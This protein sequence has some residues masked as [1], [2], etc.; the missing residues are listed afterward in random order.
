MEQF[1][2][3]LLFFCL[4]SQAPA[5]LTSQHSGFCYPLSNVVGTLCWLL[6]RQQY[7][8]AAAVADDELARGVA[9]VQQVQHYFA[10]ANFAKDACVPVHKSN[11]A[12]L[13]ARHWLICAQVPPESPGPGR[14][15][16]PRSASVVSPPV[17][18]DGWRRRARALPHVL[19][20]H[21]ARPDAH[22]GPAAAARGGGLK[23]H[24]SSSIELSIARAAYLRICRRRFPV[25]LSSS[26]H[27]CL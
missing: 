16:R 2:V 18:H 21:G 23:S 6:R 24:R 7:G 14:L 8:I 17:S 26:K 11:V 19:A 20:P 4:F 22:Q 27:R 5:L 25:V 15:R 12:V 9:L 3:L 10:P 1:L 13:P